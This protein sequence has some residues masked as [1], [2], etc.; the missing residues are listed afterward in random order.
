MNGVTRCICLGSRQ[1]IDGGVK[2]PPNNKKDKK[3]PE[4]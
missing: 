3:T 2:M 1:E 4:A